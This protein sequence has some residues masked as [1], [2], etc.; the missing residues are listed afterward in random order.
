M[1]GGDLWM[2][3]THMLSSDLHSPRFWRS[4]TPSSSAPLRTGWKMRQ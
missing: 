2:E 4:I 1:E 3:K